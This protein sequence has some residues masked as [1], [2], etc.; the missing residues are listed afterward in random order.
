MGI[1]GREVEANLQGIILVVENR[2]EP[3]IVG[4]IGMII[5]QDEVNIATMSMSRIEVGGV[6]LT[7]VNLDSSPSKT[8]MQKI[9]S[10]DAI[11]SAVLVH[12]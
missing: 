5:G 3:G 7:V 12:L 10:R 8:A 4:Q 11:E 6:A 9:S 1:N 2:D